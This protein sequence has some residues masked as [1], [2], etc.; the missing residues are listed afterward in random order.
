MIKTIGQ[1]LQ[2]AKDFSKQ[3]KKLKN[4]GKYNEALDLYYKAHN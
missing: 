2:T 1:D 3:A 4:K